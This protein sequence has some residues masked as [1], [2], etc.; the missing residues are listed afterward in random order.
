MGQIGGRTKQQALDSLSLMTQAVQ[1]IT[2]AEY[3]ARIAKAQQL[4]QQQ[5]LQK[6]QKQ[7]HKT[8]L[9]QLWMLQQQQKQPEPW[10]RKLLMQLLNYQQKLLS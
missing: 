1:P 6:Q 4:M 5:L 8:L 10:L 3:K 9:M 7:Q 2:Q